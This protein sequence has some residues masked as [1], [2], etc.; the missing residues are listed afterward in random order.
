[1]SA[2]GIALLTRP[3]TRITAR[4]EIETTSVGTLVSV[5]MSWSV[6][7]NFWTVP[8]LWLGIPNIPPTWPMATWIPTPVRK[9]IRTLRDRKFAMKP[10]LSSRAAI[11]RTAH[12][13]AASDVI[14]TYSAD[15]EVWPI[16]TSPVARIAAD[17]E[18]APTTRWRDDPKIAKNRTGR[19]SV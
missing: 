18:S 17:A 5:G 3:R 11:R 9:P 12:M 10:S 8:P 14:S 19:S 7:T 1:M 15:P 13:R 6:S 2:P 4:T 16:A